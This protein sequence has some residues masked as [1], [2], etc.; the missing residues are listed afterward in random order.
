[1]WSLPAP[2]TV[3][4]IIFHLQ[5]HSTIQWRNFTFVAAT[6]RPSNCV[7]FAFVGNFLTIPIADGGGGHFATG[8]TYDIER[9]PI[10]GFGLFVRDFVEV[11]NL[12]SFIKTKLDHIIHLA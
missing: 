5:P 2:S 7:Y 4:P 8:F 12:G 9:I 10:G 1:M 6:L 11:A 3:M